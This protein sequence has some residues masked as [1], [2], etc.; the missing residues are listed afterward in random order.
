MKCHTAEAFA[1]IANKFRSPEQL[2]RY[3]IWPERSAKMTARVKTS[4]GTISGRVTQISDFRVTVADG[5]GKTVAIDRR[6]GVEIEID[7]PLA[8]HR[9]IVMTLAN[10]AMH[11][12]TAYLETLK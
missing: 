8:A 5:S 4:Q 2:Q 7:E 6:S 1:H 3:W 11:D 12:V 10:D 9:E